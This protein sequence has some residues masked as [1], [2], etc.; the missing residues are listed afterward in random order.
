MTKIPAEPADIPDSAANES[1][2]DM[3]LKASADTRNARLRGDSRFG[4]FYSITYFLLTQQNFYFVALAADQVQFTQ[5]H[6]FTRQ[7]GLAAYVPTSPA[8]L[9]VDSFCARPHCRRAQ[10][11]TV[12][13]Q[14]ID[15]PIDGTLQWF[16]FIYQR[17]CQ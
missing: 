14:H 12:L 4:C 8:D 6:L 11:R 15:Q 2:P 10:M 17:L 1:A 5:A 7:T 16:C 3:V 13:L 9:P